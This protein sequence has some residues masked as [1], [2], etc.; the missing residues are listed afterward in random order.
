MT[1]PNMRTAAQTRGFRNKPMSSA[2]ENYL[3]LN[4][5]IHTH[6]D[7]HLIFKKL[8]SLIYKLHFTE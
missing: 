6:A 4:N 2:A 7:R 1:S 5:D 8:A 3:S